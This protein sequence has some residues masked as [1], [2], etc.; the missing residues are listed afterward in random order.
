M[1]VGPAPLPPM[2][3]IP[4]DGTGP[5]DVVVDAE[6]RVLSGVDDGRILRINPHDHRVDVVADTGGRPLGLEAL[7]DGRLLVCDAE[8]G[9]LRVNPESGIVEV[10]VEHV[11]GQRLRFCSN[12]VAASDG[13][14]YFSAS[15]RR[16]GLERW[17][18][19]LVEHSG[20]GRLFRLDPDGRHVEVLLE[21]LQFANGVTLA[22][23]ESFVAVAET[24][25]YRLTRL[26]L[27][28]EHAGTTDVLV[29]DLSGFPDNISTG[30]SGLIWITLASPR[31]QALDRLH[32]LHPLVRQLIW[33]LPEFLQPQP[34]RTLWMIAV[35]T[36]GRI[37]H[38]LQGPG[39]DYH[40]GLVTGVVEHDGRLYLGS[41]V[42]RAIAVL[43]APR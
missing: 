14:V 28:G 8:R 17:R 18:A 16:F 31:N 6:G 11:A 5:E 25:A 22:P 1:S 4:I 13:T 38:D 29:D 2:R 19:D 24:G 40:F 9:L 33:R 41:L 27:T 42:E 37:V 12:A 23:D 7:D 20:T 21:G 3:V 39:D 32:Q 10:L 35:D 30:P 43:A 36:S 15:S 34:Q 26:W